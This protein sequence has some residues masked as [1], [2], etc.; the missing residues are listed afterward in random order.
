MPLTVDMAL[1]GD[2][3]L[4][5]DAALMVDMHKAVAATATICWVLAAQRSPFCSSLPTG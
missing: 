4:M 1:A 2:V 3:A 5:V